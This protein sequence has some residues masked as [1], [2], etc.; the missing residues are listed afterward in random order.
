LLSYRKKP[1]PD[2]VSRSF[3]SRGE[4][5]TEYRIWNRKIVITFRCPLPVLNDFGAEY[6]V[7][8][9]KTP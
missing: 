5:D 7:T 2:L 4:K 1:I 8:E 6:S 9:V 3:V